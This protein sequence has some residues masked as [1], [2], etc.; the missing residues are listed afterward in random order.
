MSAT[1]TRPAAD[2]IRIPSETAA[3]AGHV[4][5][6]GVG[7]RRGAQGFTLVEILV[8]LIVLSVG[9]VL[10]LQAF[11]ASLRA[12]GDARDRLWTCILLRDAATRAALAARASTS[13]MGGSEGAWDAGHGEWKWRLMCDLMETP[14]PVVSDTVKAVA[15]HRAEIVV[16]REASAATAD[17][18]VWT[19]GFEPADNSGRR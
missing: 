9:L 2:R 14:Q 16:R 3:S 10:V 13:S 1:G 19:A 7:R 17:G 18:E 8:S 12:L 11:Q 6:A 4:A 15:L 5:A